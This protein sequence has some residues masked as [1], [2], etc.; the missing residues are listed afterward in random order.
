MPIMDGF[1]FLEKFREFNFL[2]KKPKIFI[3]SSSNHER[4]TEKGKTF[5]IDA[6][7]VKPLTKQKLE[8][9]MNAFS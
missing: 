3:L 9:L 2:Y 4:D 8:E 6:Y 1:G 7:I 5:A